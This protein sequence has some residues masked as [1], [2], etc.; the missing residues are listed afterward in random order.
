[1]TQFCNCRV[2]L[3]LRMLIT[4][5][6]P[7]VY[8][9]DWQ[10]NS[11]SS[12]LMSCKY[13]SLP[14]LKGTQMSFFIEKFLFKCFLQFRYKTSYRDRTFTV[15]K[16]CNKVSSLNQSTLLKLTIKPMAQMFFRLSENPNVSWDPLKIFWRFL[17]EKVDPNF[18][19]QYGKRTF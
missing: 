16:F 1:M 2:Q 11:S 3:C 19:K 6:K 12:W 18:K 4:L 17:K 5:K 10:N 7:F 9:F 14:I 8:K 13:L 15:A